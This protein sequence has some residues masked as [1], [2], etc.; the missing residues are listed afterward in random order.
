MDKKRP[1]IQVVEEGENLCRL[2]LDAGFVCEKRTFGQPSGS[3]VFYHA[4]GEV[5]I[6][7]GA[8]YGMLF[9]ARKIGRRGME[10]WGRL[11]A[12]RCSSRSV[13]TLVERAIRMA[14]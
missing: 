5:R 10:D 4:A 13:R 14:V 9:N 12:R 2:L 1:E 8:T 11:V 3:P 7:M 6:V